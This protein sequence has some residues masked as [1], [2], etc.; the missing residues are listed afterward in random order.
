MR[1]DSKT[2]NIHTYIQSYLQTDRPTARVTYAHNIQAILTLHTRETERQ[3]DRQRARHT[4]KQNDIQLLVQTDT[5][6]YI[7]TGRNTYI[8][9]YIQTDTQRRNLKT[10]KMT[11]SQTDKQTYKVIYDNTRQY[12]KREMYIIQDNAIQRP[13]TYADIHADNQ[14]ADGQS[15]RKTARQTE[16]HTYRHTYSQKDRHIHRQAEWLID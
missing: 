8:P 15:A 10:D 6:T 1:P 13:E 14:T 11:I 12:N 5:Q 7:Q 9:S 16:K 2:P 3:R 4:D